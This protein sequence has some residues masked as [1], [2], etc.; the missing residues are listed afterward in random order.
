[1]K[2]FL[3][4]AELFHF[5]I[6][7]DEQTYFENASKNNALTW[8]FAQQYS[9]TCISDCSFGSSAVY[10]DYFL[11]RISSDLPNECRKAS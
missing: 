9:L 10:N 1:M 2:I 8:T 3:V 5:D 4:A 11:S 6:Q 7:M